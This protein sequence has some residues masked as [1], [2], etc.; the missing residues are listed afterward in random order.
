MEGKAFLKYLIATH[1]LTKAQMLTC[2]TE[3]SSKK[4]PISEILI[5]QGCF[6]PKSLKQSVL[7]FQESQKE[8][9]QMIPSDAVLPAFSPEEQEQSI[10]EISALIQNTK[11][12]IPP[13]FSEESNAERTPFFSGKDLGFL[14]TEGSQKGFLQKFLKNK[15]FCIGR[16]D[17]CDFVIKEDRTVSSQ[18]CCFLL[19]ED[20]LTLEDKSS[21]GTRLNGRLIK[22]EKVLLK[23]TD[24]IRIGKTHFQITSFSQIPSNQRMPL[25]GEHLADIQKQNESLK[26]MEILGHFGS[27]HIIEEIGK[28]SF[29]TVYKALDQSSE[30]LV[31]LKVFA[32]VEIKEIDQQLEEQSDPQFQFFKRS[33]REAE[34]LKELKHPFIIELYEVGEIQLEQEKKH[35]IALEF[36]QGVDL[37]YHI[38]AQG[39]MPWQK[40][41]KLLKML[42][43]ALDYMHISGIAH[44]DLKPHNV[45]Y[46][47]I[48]E[49]AKIIDL[50][51]GKC[52]LSSKQKT[53]FF[54]TKTGTALGTPDFMPIE[55][56]EDAKSAN[57]LVDIYS[58]GATAYYL[59]ASAFPHGKYN[60][61][62]ELY[63]AVKN[64]KIIP[65]EKMADS[66][67]P[68]E[69][70][71][72][73]QKMMA[74]EAKNRHQTCK[75]LL[76]ELQE[77]TNMLFNKTR[78]A[79]HKEGGKEW[80]EK[81]F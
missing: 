12:E 76:Q 20:N 61:F 78:L 24:I 81:P 60:S 58:L 22:K 9:H 11:K 7:D 52:F 15:P 30:K 6:T 79:S 1:Q 34:F 25:F 5:Q 51:L 21:N 68:K 4:R 18:H 42:A 44:R 57:H 65:L 55:Q 8:V 59:F 46:N 48:S 67:V 10:Q 35:F 54:N 26:E 40:V 16:V 62:K 53:T 75:E 32:G 43:Q 3:Y 31:A 71:Q 64:Q 74:F 14:V 36:F 37:Y 69:L 2:W 77:L 27:Y 73:I 19:Q 41:L 56:W 50:G 72:F 33:M 17:S 70:I 63:H 66:S 13:H 28:G 47:D 23:N 80:K 29:G 45:L 38:K 49:I 39:K